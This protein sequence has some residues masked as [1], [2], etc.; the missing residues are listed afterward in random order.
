MSEDTISFSTDKPLN[1]QPHAIQLEWYCIPFLHN[2]STGSYIPLLPNTSSHQDQA[3]TSNS[4]KKRLRGS[5]WSK[6]EED[7]LVGYVSANGLRCWTSA[8]K[9]M[10]Y[11]FHTN[12]TVRIG[13]H[14]REKWYNY[15]NPELKKGEWSVQEDHL[16]LTLQATHGK[17]WSKIAKHLPGRTENSVKNRWYSIMKKASKLYG[18]PMDQSADIARM[19]LSD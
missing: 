11:Y 1:A 3:Q 17:R 4:S 18:I 5:D 9:H 7:F 2:Y 14:C 12:Q 19:L 16:L 6:A 10:N 13:R 15:L 8:A